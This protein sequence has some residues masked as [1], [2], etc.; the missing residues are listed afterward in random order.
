MM[1]D[2]TGNDKNICLLG[3]KINVAPIALPNSFSQDAI[4]DTSVIELTG[5]NA[6]AKFD[7]DKSV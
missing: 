5:R 7:R 4:M 2:L 1:D 6:I 3:L